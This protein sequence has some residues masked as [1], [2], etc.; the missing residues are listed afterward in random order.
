MSSP[1]SAPAWYRNR[2]LWVAVILVTAAAAAA[3]LVRAA[4]SDADPADLNGQ[5]SK[6]MQVVLEQADPASH[7]GH[8][9]HVKRESDKPASVVCGVTVYGYEPTD[10]S[11]LAE[12]DRVY[13]FHMCGVAEP[14]L[15]WDWAVKLVGPLIMDMST[16]P[17][18]IQVAEAT[19][20]MRYVD[21]VKELF[22][23]PWEQQALTTA[24]TDEGMADLRRRYDAA[25][26]L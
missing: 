25:A 11:T 3:V 23:D 12:V 19:A 21:R 9:E 7:H 24:L 16:E 5:I 17:P 1:T 2:F 10:A 4:G 18:G 26:G 8:G 14:K 13:G 15:P 20:T 6:R 22:P